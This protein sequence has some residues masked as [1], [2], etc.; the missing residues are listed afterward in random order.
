MINL[1]V[2]TLFFFSALLS[3]EV[4]LVVIKQFIWASVFFC[5]LGAVLKKSILLLQL[6]KAMNPDLFIC[7]YYII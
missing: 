5:F 1:F 6:I 2:I 4:V 7:C 3:V